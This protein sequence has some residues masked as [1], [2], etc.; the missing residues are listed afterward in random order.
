MVLKKVTVTYGKCKD[1][2][3]AS[4]IT[5]YLPSTFISLAAL[6]TGLKRRCGR[7]GAILPAERVKAEIVKKESQK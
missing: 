4:C 2:G 3:S 6:E 1:C 5:T 7:C